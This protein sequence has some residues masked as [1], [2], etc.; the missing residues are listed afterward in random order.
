VPILQ[1]ILPSSLTGGMLPKNRDHRSRAG[2]VPCA[3]GNPRF[4]ASSGDGGWHPGAPNLGVGET[5]GDGAC[6]DPLVTDGAGAPVLVEHA[7]S[8]K[9]S[10]E[11]KISRS[12]TTL[13]VLESM[14][15]LS[16][17]VSKDG[18]VAFL[19]PGNFCLSVVLSQV[20]PR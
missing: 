20:S 12:Q 18:S 14:K 9:I 16:F 13:L 11:Q 3:S 5:V 6:D 7:M 4:D 19:R 2:V 8:T 17:P 1:I 15:R 10:R